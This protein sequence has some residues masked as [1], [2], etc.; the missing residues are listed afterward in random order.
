MKYIV[1]III[2]KPINEQI[3]MSEE[4]DIHKN[5]WRIS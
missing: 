2:E 1:S 5:I 3:K 4:N